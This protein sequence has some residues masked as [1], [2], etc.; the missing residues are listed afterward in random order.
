MLPS[1]AWAWRGAAVLGAAGVYAVPL[2]TSRLAAHTIVCGQDGC[3][4][5]NGTGWP[6]HGVRSA[7]FHRKAIFVVSIFLAIFILFIIG[8]AVFLRDRGAPRSTDAA[9]AREQT[10]AAR[11]RPRGY[12]GRVLR[13]IRRPLRRRAVHSDRR[14]DVEAAIEMD[15][16]APGD[17]EV[18]AVRPAPGESDAAASASE[19]AVDHAPEPVSAPQP[20]LGTYPP[21]YGEGTATDAATPAQPPARLHA[22]VA[23]DDKQV[24]HALQSA[25]SAPLL[26]GA[27]CTPSAPPIDVAEPGTGAPH[28]DKGKAPTRPAA[29]PMLAS[30]PAKHAEAEAEQSAL[31]AL[32][33]SAPDW[34]WSATPLPLY[35]PAGAEGPSLR[36]TATMPMASA[37][38]LAETMPLASAPSIPETMPSA[39]APS[40]AEE[41]PVPLGSA[42]CLPATPSAPCIPCASATPTARTAP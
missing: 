9:G 16:V 11:L 42:P 14:A 23:T 17:D 39:S 38:S 41:A 19:H 26:P 6:R 32:L 25:S 36:G 5:D 18:A 28:R 15:V 33:P 21:A 22:H 40:I 31:S 24:L 2:S 30:T 13:R 37:P 1:A 12:R 20:T 4:F 7:W 29:D 34:G 10:R 27:A 3:L 8:F 35:I